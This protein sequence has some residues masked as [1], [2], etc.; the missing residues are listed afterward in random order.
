MDTNSSRHPAS[1]GRTLNLALWAAQLTIALSFCIA[2][3]M[4]IFMPIPT[5]AAIWPWAGELPS[6]A[7]RALGLIDFL[8]GVGILLPSLTRIKPRLSLTAAWCCIA[9]Q[10]CAMVFHATR[11]EFAALPVNLVLLALC[12]LVVWGRDQPCPI[13]ERGIA[14]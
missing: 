1:P 14:S 13:A 10:C 4:K 2:A 5:L 6:A 9:L 3:A 8:G 7:V 11:A 12:A